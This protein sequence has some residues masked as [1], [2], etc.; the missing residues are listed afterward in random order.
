MSG[1]SIAYHL[2]THKTVDRRLFTDLL[3]RYERFRS[4]A[5]AVYISMGAYSLEDHRLIHRN[6][7][8]TRMVAFDLDASIVSRQNFNRPVESC[9]CIEKNSGDFISELSAILESSGY[10][11][12]T[13]VVIWLDYTDPKQIGAQVREFQSLLDKLREGDVVR[14]TVNANPKELDSKATAAP[15]RVTKVMENQFSTLK[16]FIGDYLPSTATSSD[17]TAEGLAR[18]LAQAFGS[19]ALKALP[20][21]GRTIFSP[22]SIVRY[23]DTTQML[24][25]TGVLVARDGVNKLRSSMGLEEWPFSSEGWTDIKKLIVPAITLRERLFLERSILRKEDDEIESELG[26]SSFGE[27]AVG[28]FLE[29]YR[30]YYRFYPTFLSAEI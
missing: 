9:V 20:A 17:M 7:G 14:V 28:E 10:V 21:T 29:S 16:Q 30:K 18:V 6:L 27:V 19:A 15:E 1:A 5:N 26:F 4:L 3:G 8:I 25:I 22:L 12:A 23:A 11:E 2:R 13:S 24:S